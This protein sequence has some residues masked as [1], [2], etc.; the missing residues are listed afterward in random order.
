[1][2]RLRRLPA[3]CCGPL[4][5]RRLWRRAR[6]P[7]LFRDCRVPRLDSVSIRETAEGE[8]GEKG[9]RYR[10]GIAVRARAA[11]CHLCPQGFDI[12]V[13]RLVRCCSASGPLCGL[14]CID[15]GGCPGCAGR[16][17]RDS[18][19]G[20]CT[21]TAEGWMRGR[22]WLATYRGCPGRRKL[23]PVDSRHSTCR[24]QPGSIYK[25]G[26]YYRGCGLSLVYTSPPSIVLVL[27]G[28]IT[29]GPIRAK[30]PPVG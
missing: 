4:I 23:R 15:W 11:Y 16:E 10:L 3:R 2:R 27:H 18:W 8:K 19:R 21:G 24:G 30:T 17:G 26:A 22:G 20:I 29:I 7:L 14:V 13:R 1:M 25:Y 9:E 28:D 12:P 5:R 6:A